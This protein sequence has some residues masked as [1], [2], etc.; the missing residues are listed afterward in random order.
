MERTVVQDIVRASFPDDVPVPELLLK[1]A[2]WEETSE[3][4]LPGQLE[5]TPHGRREAREWADGDEQNATQRAFHNHHFR[6]EN[7]PVRHNITPIPRIRHRSRDDKRP[8]STIIA[9]VVPCKM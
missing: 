2:A 9:H 1:L 8:F 7:G 6:R 3:L 4:F 5:F